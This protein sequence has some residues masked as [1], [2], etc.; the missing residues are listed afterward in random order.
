MFAFL[1]CA[2]VVSGLF[3]LP[4]TGECAKKKSGK[5]AG[6]KPADSS[7]PKLGQDGKD[8][9]WVPTAPEHVGIMLDLAKVSPF[10]YV[11]DLGSGDGVLV[12]AAAKRGAKALGIE[13]ESPLVDMARR[14]AI[15]ENVSER[16][17]FRQGDFFESDF[18]QATVLTM[19][20]L[21]DINIK[22]RPKILEMAPGSRVVSNTFGMGEWE[23]EETLRP[24]VVHPVS[25]KTAQFPIHL[26]IVPANIEGTWQ[27]DKGEI[28]FVQEFQRI[29][30][31]LTCEGTPRNITGKVRGTRLT[32]TAD[33]L[34]Y[35]GTIS[36]TTISG[37]RSDGT[38]W[39]ASR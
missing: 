21:E 23:P 27:M 31:T 5:S 17:E 25:K 7:A 33:G 4:A 18:S 20:L 35:A 12:I 22:L 30:G 8:I 15:K 24:V 1:C 9:L 34:E 14:A 6:Q 26:W 2:A 38:A 11:V 10:D 37:T 19:F 16:T 13:Y 29:T 36:P 3:L 32:F 28:Q 39:T